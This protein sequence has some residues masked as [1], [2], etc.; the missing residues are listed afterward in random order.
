MKSN[1]SSIY[2]SL[3]CHKT[4]SNQIEI[5]W[6]SACFDAEFLIEN[7][8]TVQ[9]VWKMTASKTNLAVVAALVMGSVLFIIVSLNCQH[10][11]FIDP[12]VKSYFFMNVGWIARTNYS[13][14]INNNGIFSVW[15][16]Q[17]HFLMTF[18]VQSFRCLNLTF[19]TRFLAV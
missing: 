10:K 6:A 7:L 13:T 12:Y 1:S 9:T 15:L 16:H 8:Y 18:T 14:K 17:F 5:N 3:A 4:D 11:S 19:Y 2:G